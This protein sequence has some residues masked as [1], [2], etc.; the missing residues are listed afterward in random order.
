S[1]GYVSLLSAT[2]NT[3]IAASIL[4]IEL[5]GP[6]IGAYTS[7]ACIISF[8]MSGHR[9]IYPSQILRIKK[10]NTFIIKDGDE[11]GDVEVEYFKKENFLEGLLK[12]I[13]E[14]KKKS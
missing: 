8:L 10:S 9:S 12:K 4:S 6:K 1:I 14:N 5:F 13:K 7:L 2:A 3:P 11:I